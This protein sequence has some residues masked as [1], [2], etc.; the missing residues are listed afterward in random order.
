MST[1]VVMTGGKALELGGVFG[2]G[3]C[4]LAGVISHFLAITEFW[5]IATISMYK[6]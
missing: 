4:Y 6:V 3:I 1:Y 5:I 2:E